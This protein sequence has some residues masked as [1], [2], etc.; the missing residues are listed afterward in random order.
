MTVFT[1][2]DS[3][4]NFTV[5]FLCETFTTICAYIGLLAC[6]C[7]FVISHILLSYKAFI[8]IWTVVWP[9]A[10]VDLFMF[11]NISFVSELFLAVSASVKFLS[12]MNT[13]M[14]LHIIFP[15]KFLVAI[16][17]REWFLSCV[18]IHMLLQGGVLLT[19]F[20]THT[21]NVNCFTI[22]I[23]CLKLSS[24]FACTASW[25][26]SP[27]T[28]TPRSSSVSSVVASS[29]PSSSTLFIGQ[30]F[31]GISECLCLFASKSVYN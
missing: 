9:L 17:T 13:H 24:L 12:C 16:F 8:T 2:V 27:S 29:R 21:A 10:G 6:V 3:F 30:S 25:P 22:V 18:D 28:C 14:N 23:N 20:A 7:L 26:A 15:R 5:S 31:L 19:L 4:V 11:F 1:G